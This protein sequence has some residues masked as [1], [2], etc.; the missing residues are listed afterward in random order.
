[1]SFQTEIISQNLDRFERLI[2]DPQCL[3]AQ[4]EQVS[5]GRTRQE[6]LALKSCLSP[7]QLEFLNSMADAFCRARKFLA[8]V[9]KKSMEQYLRDLNTNTDPR[10]AL[11]DAYRF[12]N[13]GRDPDASTLQ[14]INLFARN[15]ISSFIRKKSSKSVIDT[16]LG[17]GSDAVSKSKNG[18]KNKHI[19][20]FGENHNS[21]RLDDG[22]LYH[23]ASEW[24]EANLDKLYKAGYRSLALEVPQDLDLEEWLKQGNR[25]WS[26]PATE[27]IATVEQRI[28][29]VDEYLRRK[30]P[31]GS[32]DMQTIEFFTG[33]N[34]WLVD[35]RD[36]FKSTGK[37]TLRKAN[38]D[39]RDVGRNRFLK[40][41]RAARQKGFEIVLSDASNKLNHDHERLLYFFE[42]YFPPAEKISEQMK[43][44]RDYLRYR[45]NIEMGLRDRAM[46]NNLYRALKQ[47]PGHV[48]GIFGSG[49]T[50]NARGNGSESAYQRLVQS[51]VPVVSVKLEYPGMS[52]NEYRFLQDNLDINTTEKPRIMQVR[53]MPYAAYGLI[54]GHISTRIEEGRFVTECVDNPRIGSKCPFDA[55]ILFPAPYIS[56]AA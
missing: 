2:S 26:P 23:P 29:D 27:H 52:G 6:A 50:R 19:I 21:L 4:I 43:I 7:I 20:L 39:I 38:E 44:V 1:M 36:E 11:T 31:D 55:V 56:R 8:G 13:D 46:A 24:I 22:S 35:K 18:D 15:F 14:R 37:I 32:R 54:S 28:K 9:S 41:A 10:S 12:A 3:A 40:L 16:L 30:I 42:Q 34:R 53:D 49:H 5:E 47:S 48:I 45:R 25:L 33:V 17:L 51:H